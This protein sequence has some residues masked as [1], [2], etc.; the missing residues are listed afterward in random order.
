MKNAILFL[1]TL[2]AV[3][4]APAK[5]PTYKE[6]SE[7]VAKLRAE[8]ADLRATVEVLERAATKARPSTQPASLHTMEADVAAAKDLANR[9]R[10][11]ELKVHI[12][13]GGADAKEAAELRE[14]QAGRIQTEIAPLDSQPIHDE[15]TSVGDVGPLR[16]AVIVQV[17]GDKEALCETWSEYRI[18]DTATFDRKR[19][20]ILVKGFDFSK[21]TDGSPLRSGNT[22]FWISKTQKYETAIG[23]SKTVLVAEAAK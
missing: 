23:V 16:F 7:E 14:L 12:R 9:R 8:N 21:A 1:L 10:I 6:L 5:P 13:V 20:T 4:A 17:L 3:A 19:I 22:L 2:A 11:S 18:G 15:G